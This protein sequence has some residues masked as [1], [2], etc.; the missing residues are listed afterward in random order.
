M[1]QHLAHKANQDL[2]KSWVMLLSQEIFEAPNW[3][4]WSLKYRKTKQKTELI[5]QDRKVI[6]WANAILPFFLTYALFEKDLQ[7]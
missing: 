5:G 7:L 1:Y 6:I 4:I 2:F 3:K